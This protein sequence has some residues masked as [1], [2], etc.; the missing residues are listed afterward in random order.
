MAPVPAFNTGV[1]GDISWAEATFSAGKAYCLSLVPLSMFQHVFIELLRGEGPLAR[2]AAALALALCALLRVALE[3][4]WELLNVAPGARMALETSES[5]I[6]CRTCIFL[7]LRFRKFLF[8]QPGA[9][10]GALLL[11]AAL[12]A[13]RRQWRK[14]SFILLLLTR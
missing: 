8:P 3:M 14:S 7:P 1:R 13:F 2:V 9:A 4:L 5:P 11:L 10:Y 6:S 12:E